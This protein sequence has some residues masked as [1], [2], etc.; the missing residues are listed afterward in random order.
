LLH[1]PSYDLWPINAEAG[2]M[3]PRGLADPRQSI[4]VSFAP[5]GDVRGY[6]TRFEQHVRL[7]GP[8][9]DWENV[10]IGA[11]PPPVRTET[12]WLLVYHGVAGKLSYE[13]PQQGVR[14]SAGAMILDATD[15]THV[16]WRDPAPLL[17][18]E[19]EDESTGT[20]PHVVF[21]TAID[22]R[23]NGSLDLYYGMADDKIGV[24][25]LEATRPGV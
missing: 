13:W 11:G 6:P 2:T 8:E 4:W 25:R 17:Q 18:P 3:Y 20:V 9:Q 12:G 19:T 21:P 7:A 10:K 22:P 1:R 14:Y 24:A 16:L 23:G 5:V 15:V